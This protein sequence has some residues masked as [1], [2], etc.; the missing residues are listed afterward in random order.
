MHGPAMHS[1]CSSVKS[2]RALEASL[3]V[4]IQYSRSFRL[5]YLVFENFGFRKVGTEVLIRIIGTQLE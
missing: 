2:S 3:A 1:W 4:G 5:V